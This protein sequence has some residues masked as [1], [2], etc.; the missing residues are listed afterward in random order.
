MV[1]Y[2]AD[3]SGTPFQ[4]NPILIPVLTETLGCVSF[5]KCQIGLEPR[6]RTAS[7]MLRPAWLAE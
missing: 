3:P 2:P 5:L 1:D 7:S 6:C 4:V